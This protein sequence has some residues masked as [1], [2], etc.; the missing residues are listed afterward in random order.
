MATVDLPQLQLRMDRAPV[1]DE[2]VA[3]LAQETSEKVAHYLVVDGYDMCLTLWEKPPTKAEV[4]WR[5]PIAAGI[6]AG[7]TTDYARDMNHVWADIYWLEDEPNTWWYVVG[8]M[9]NT[10]TVKITK[11]EDAVKCPCGKCSEFQTI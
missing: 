1:P 8:R 5:D 3:A 9:G 11:R 2:I 6:N 7:H 10:H 4:V